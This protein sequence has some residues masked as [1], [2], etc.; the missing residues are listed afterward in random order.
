MEQIYTSCEKEINRRITAYTTLILSFFIS[1]I[2][3]SFSYIINYFNIFIYVI[4]IGAVILFLTRIIVVKYL[5]SLLK[6]DIGLTNK[7]IRKNKTKYLIKDINKI[8]IKRTSKGYIR[9]IKIKFNKTNT[10]INNSTN[11]IEKFI[12]ELQEYLPKNVIKKT[13]HEPL[14]YDHPL[15]YFFFGILVSF[16]SIESISLLN[17]KYINLITYVISSLSIIMGIYFIVYK[18]IYKRDEKSNKITDYIWGLFFVI[19]GLFAL[20]LS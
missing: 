8:I 5:R 10:Y 6:T 14:D 13:I 19:G 7:Y 9:E 12:K 2:I 1:S 11:D 17:T 15:F 16:I 20:L 18:P 4:I 3:F